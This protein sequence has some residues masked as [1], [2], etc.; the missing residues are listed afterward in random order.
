MFVMLKAPSVLRFDESLSNLNY[1]NI[2]HFN[3]TVIEVK[4]GG[5]TAVFQNFLTFAFSSSTASKYI[6]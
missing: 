1:V 3:I 2:I 4:H 6:N 5:Y